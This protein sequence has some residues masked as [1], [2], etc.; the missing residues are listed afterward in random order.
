[1]TKNATQPQY[2]QIA[3]GATKT[4]DLY[5]TVAGWTTGSTMSISL[6][7]D[8]AAVANGT[9]SATASGHNVV[10]S[11]RSASP[12]TSPAV[13]AT[14]TGDF[15]DGYLLKNFTSNAITYSK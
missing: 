2:Q 11:D 8:T 1:M 5:G 12:H 10:W 9:P 7:A 13:G 14:A 15:T 4:Y 6:A 3:A